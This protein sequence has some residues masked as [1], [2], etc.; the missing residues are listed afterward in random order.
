M[1]AVQDWVKE[2]LLAIGKVTKAM[3]KNRYFE[4]RVGLRGGPFDSESTT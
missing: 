3:T 1:L 4:L 2:R